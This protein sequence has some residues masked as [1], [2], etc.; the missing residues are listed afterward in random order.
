MLYMRITTLVCLALMVGACAPLEVKKQCPPGTQNLPDCPPAD[1]VNDE[2]VNKLYTSRTWLPPDKQTMDPIKAGN[3]AQVPVNKARAKVIGPTY[4]EALHS[5]AAKIW[6]I[7]NAEHTV[8]VMYY[9][10]AT[11]PVGYAVLGALCNAVKRGVDVRIMVDSLGSMRPAHNELRALETC[12]EE[13]GFMRN[14]QGQITTKKARVQVVIFNAIT[15]FQFNRRSHDKLL[16]VDGHIPEKAAVMTGGR[17][18]SLDYYGIKEIFRPPVITA[19]F[20]GI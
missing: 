6:L 2:G 3:E 8:D 13:A 4:D 20:S 10:F 11:D 5:L 18:I 19:A 9:I 1:A 12:G 15:K 17:N 14:A 16:V 7:E